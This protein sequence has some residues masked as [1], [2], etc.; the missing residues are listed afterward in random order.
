MPS[1]YEQQ[2]AKKNRLRGKKEGDLTVG[3]TKQPGNLRGDVV[4]GGARQDVAPR[5]EQCPSGA[6]LG[7]GVYRNRE[8]ANWRLFM[9]TVDEFRAVSPRA[10][11]H[12]GSPKL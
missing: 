7:S 6:S 2:D 4:A 10:T 1:G 3:E 11:L 12:C 5:A 9:R 8:F